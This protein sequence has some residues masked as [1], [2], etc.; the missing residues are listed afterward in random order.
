MDDSELYYGYSKNTLLILDYILKYVKP[1]NMSD[2]EFL[3]V[4]EL[5]HVGIST[6]SDLSDSLDLSKS[7]TSRTV[8][9]LV[10]KGVLQKLVLDDDRRKQHVTLTSEGAETSMMLERKIGLVLEYC[11]HDLTSKERIAFEKINGTIRR[12]IENIDDILE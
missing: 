11:F 5:G 9:V 10:S 8:D 2:P 4:L 12:S 7:Q 6:I 1:D 3:I